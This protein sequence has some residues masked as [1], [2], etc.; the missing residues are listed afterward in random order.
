MQRIRLIPTVLTVI[1]PLVVAI[2]TD[3]I[4]VLEPDF[5]CRSGRL[6]PRRFVCDGEVD[7]GVRDESDERNCSKH[8][9]SEDNPSSEELLE[10]EYVSPKEYLKPTEEGTTV[11]DHLHDDVSAIGQSWNKMLSRNKR[12]VLNSI[13]K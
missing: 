6:I 8:E 5:E 1:S 12:P 7:C 13:L 3:S 10:I 9:S 2:V 11:D 4:A